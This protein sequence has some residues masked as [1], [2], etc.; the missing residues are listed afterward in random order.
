MAVSVWEA[1]WPDAGVRAM[2]QSGQYFLQEC[3]DLSSVARRKP[4]EKQAWWHTS[5]IPSLED[6]WSSPD[7]QPSSRGMLSQ[8]VS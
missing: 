2:A 8:A 1:M 7:N 6:P 5:V 4:R 3:E